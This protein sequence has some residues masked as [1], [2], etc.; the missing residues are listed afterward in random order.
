[1]YDDQRR[2]GHTVDYKPLK[3]LT[4]KQRYACGYTWFQRAPAF[5]REPLVSARHG[6]K[7]EAPPPGQ[8]TAREAERVAEGEDIFTN[9]TARPPL[10]PHN[11]PISG[12]GE[13]FG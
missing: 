1:M 8:R 3:T 5:N 2:A 11:R 4:H 10:A 7:G 12:T 9:R 13:K 6:L